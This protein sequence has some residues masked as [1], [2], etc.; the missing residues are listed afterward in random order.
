MTKAE[1]SAVLAGVITRMT[2][3][4]LL[5]KSATS[6]VSGLLGL[7]FGLDDDDEEEEKTINQMVTQ[8]L[9]STFAS[10]IL[11]RDFG[12]VSKTAINYGFEE[13]VTKEYLEGLRT[14]EYDPYKDA[15]L[16][17]SLQTDPTTG[18]IKSW[19]NIPNFMGA[20]GPIA[21]TG[22]LALKTLTAEEKKEAKA[23]ER[24]EKERNIRLPLEIMGNL[25]Y[26]PLYKEIRK[27]VMD[28]IYKDLKNNKID[29]DLLKRTSPD[30]YERI[31]SYEERSS[32][33]EIEDRT[34]ERKKEIENRMKRN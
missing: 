18:E 14:G 15:I 23:I 4:N 30:M 32:N 13:L 31:K 29:M 5:I 27:S 19:E 6:G 16:F 34:K 8:S 28:D 25:G 24:Q 9:T 7:A 10:L 22:A 11:G 33:K 17:N 12:N 3:Y 1:G 21:K 20:Y 2:V 26:I